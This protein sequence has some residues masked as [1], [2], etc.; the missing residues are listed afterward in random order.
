MYATPDSTSRIV[1]TLPNRSKVCADA[2]ASGYG[3]RRVKL[4]DGREG[5]V[6]DSNVS[7]M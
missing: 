5:F 7:L 4:P 2:S 1:G 6:D 3:F